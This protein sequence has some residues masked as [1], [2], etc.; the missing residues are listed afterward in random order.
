[1]A[2]YMSTQKNRASTDLTRLHFT[3]LLLSAVSCSREPDAVPLPVFMSTPLRTRTAV[4]GTRFQRIEAAKSGLTFSNELKPQN[5]VPYIYSGGG[6]T[7]SDYDGDG[8]PDIYLLS[9]DGPNKLFRQVAPMRFED[10]TMSA[11]GLDGGNA[12]GTA[13]A[14]V[15]IDGDGDLD[16]YVCNLESPNLLFQNKGDGTFR[17]CAGSFG[18]AITAASTGCAF[19]DYDNDGDLDLYLVTNRVFG[20]R[21]PQEIVDEVELPKDLRKS[22]L[23]LFPP[24]PRFN[25]DRD[26]P[27]VPEGYADFYSITKDQIFAAGQCDYLMRNDGYGQWHDVTEQAG[28]SGHGNGLSATWWDFDNDGL[29]DLYVANDL[30]SPDQLWHN[31][32]GGKFLDVT[33][34]LLPHTAYFGMG[35]DF[36]D[37]NNDGLFDFCVADMSSTTHYMGKMLMG[38]MG[39]RR[40]FLMNSDPQQ[41]MR[42]ALFINTGT[43]RFLEAGYLSGLASTDWTWTVRFADLDE[44]GQLDLFATNGIP[45]FEDNPDTVAE[46]RRLWRMNKRTEALQLARRIP[47]VKE[48]NIARRNEG[49]LKFTDISAI[50]GLDE[51]SV[52]QAAVVADLDR[53]GDLDIVINNLNAEASL[54]ENCTTATHHAEVALRGTRSN[55]FGVGCRVELQ[56]G[57]KTQTRLVMLARG[58]MSS[59]EA[60][61]HFGLDSSTRIDRLTIQWPSG[62]HQE[63]TDLAA[64][65]LFTIQESDGQP[66]L[67]PSPLPASQPIFGPGP[68]LPAKHRERDFDDFALQPLLPHRLSKHGPGIAW[69]DINGDG[70]DDMFLCGAAGQSDSLMIQTQDGSFKILEG[71]WRE[72]LECEDLGV[73]LIDTDADGDLDILVAGGGVEAIGHEERLGCRLYQN[74]GNGI[75]AKTDAGALTNLRTSRACLSA[76]DYDRDGDLD[77]FLGGD[78]IPGRFPEATPSLLLR[79]D[80]GK[81]VDVTSEVAPSL[82]NTGMVSSAVWTDIDNDGYLDLAIAAQWQPIRVFGNDGGNRLVDKT[83][84]LGFSSIHGQWNGIAA[85]DLDNDGDMDLV[86]TNL[87]LNSKYQATELQPM[88]LYAADFDQNG[89]LDVIEAKYRNNVLLPVRGRSCSAGAIPKIANQF[90]S[91]DAFARATLPEIYGQ[92]ELEQAQEL[93]CNQLRNVVF[94]NQNGYFILHPLPHLAQIAPGYGIGIADFDGDGV[95]DIVLAQNS[96]SPEPETGRLD[97]GLGLMLRGTGLMQ[98]V[99]IPALTSGIMLPDDQKALAVVDLDNDAVPDFVIATNNGPL[100][101]FVTKPNV[102]DHR[103]TVRLHGG[104]GNPTAIGARVTL[105]RPDGTQQV[106]EL[107]AGEGYLTQVPACAF[108]S[109]A[110]KDSHIEIRWPDGTVSSHALTT[111]TDKVEFKR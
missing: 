28:F 85:A 84:E 20:P 25:S 79:N 14:F 74:R 95:L 17:E 81:F 2:D 18:L 13:A 66:P 10:V 70:R 105:Q 34:Q 5:V 65:Q 24:P 82:S 111:K 57:G 9:L 32:G 36:G 56:A 23:Q 45:R 40:W 30:E 37:I 1:M 55:R 33:R 94:E 88:R 50:W 21:L 7:V 110:T 109:R 86:V 59:G 15:D 71:P 98:F 73:L 38:S 42:N 47:P 19:A 53:D 87:G 83:A 78:V 69:G 11:G 62:I 29:L 60:V 4:E 22:R 72:D 41:Y 31:L 104:N 43:K 44:D 16:L 61:E 68:S 52:G 90:P 46:F 99:I 107:H 93:H 12:W 89:T 26:T 6:A 49:N 97:G 39:D 64:D 35:S 63:F 108:F 3:A 103:L 106:Q 54:L 27:Q 101:T 91:F 67:R 96:F 58:Y 77:L 76:A 48:R 51:E 75:F 8:L 92:K 100:H 102:S 80:G